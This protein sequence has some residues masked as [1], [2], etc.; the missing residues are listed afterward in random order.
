HPGRTRPG[1]WSFLVLLRRQA[2]LQADGDAEGVHAVEGLHPGHSVHGEP[3]LALKLLDGLFRA[4]AE[5]MTPLLAV[6]GKGPPPRARG[7]VRPERV[8]KLARR[9]QARS[10]EQP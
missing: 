7:T 8:G 1:H 2:L 5:R 6:D 4:V 3:R 10:S 9:E